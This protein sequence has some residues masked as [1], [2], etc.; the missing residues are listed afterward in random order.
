M[1]VQEQIKQ[2][3]DK[4]E[5]GQTLFLQTWID[6]QLLFVITSNPSGTYTIHRYYP[7]KENFTYCGY[8]GK[9]LQ[10]CLDEL[11]RITDDLVGALKTH[12]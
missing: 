5:E 12:I 3:R 7:F 9:T 11:N 4:C 10:E 2:Y 6:N 8:P 1:T